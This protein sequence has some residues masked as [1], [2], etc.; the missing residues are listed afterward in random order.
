MTQPVPLDGPQSAPTD[1]SRHEVPA[2]WAMVANEDAT[3]TWSQVWA[4]WRTRDALEAY[5]Q[6]LVACRDGLTAKWPPQRSEAARAFINR[7]NIMIDEV[8][9]TASA[10]AANASAAGDIADALGGA[11]RELQP[12][13]EQWQRNAQ[14]ESDAATVISVSDWGATSGSLSPMS[15]AWRDD[16][17]AQARA[18]VAKAERAVFDHTA[19]LTAAPAGQPINSIRPLS[20]TG[21]GETPVGGGTRP[22]GI[23]PPLIPPLSDSPAPALLPAAGVTDVLLTGQSVAVPSAGTAPALPAG[24]GPAGSGRSWFVSTP[25]GRALAPGAVIG[26][27]PV[28]AGPGR[29]PGGGPVPSP[30]RSPAG[31]MDQRGQPGRVLGGAQQPPAEDPRR[32]R[33]P[34]GIVGGYPPMGIGGAVGGASSPSPR[35]ANTPGRVIGSRPRSDATYTT[36]TGHTVVVSS[37]GGPQGPPRPQPVPPTDPADPW[38]VPKGVRPVLEPGPEPYHD[39]GPGVIGID[40]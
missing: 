19:Q 2:L 13:Y 22:S 4:W 16:L 1:W 39:P 8:S 9:T 21:G 3:R 28:T 27:D 17:N 32:G 11:R 6:Q 7:L 40:R 26:P 23:Q 14:V 36:A 12:L 18:A 20:D 25:L 29:G 38:Q 30:G 10:A 5:R 33:R 15:A 37:P 24:D 31:A 35:R 34:A